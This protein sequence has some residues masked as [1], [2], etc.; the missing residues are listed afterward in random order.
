VCAAP[1][2]IALLPP[3]PPAGAGAAA[4]SL[5]PVGPPLTLRHTTNVAIHAYPPP[6]EKGVP[7]ACQLQRDRCIAGGAPIESPLHW[8]TGPSVGKTIHD[9]AAVHPRLESGGTLYIETP[10]RYSR[11]KPSFD[12]L[13]SWAAARGSTVAFAGIDHTWTAPFVLVQDGELLDAPATKAFW[14]HVS[15]LERYSGYVTEKVRHTPALREIRGGAVGSAASTSTS[16]STA[17]AT[18]TSA[19]AAAAAAAAATT[20]TTTTSS[21]SSSLSSLA[22]A[23]AGSA[24]TGCV[25]VYTRVSKRSPRDTRMGTPT[26]NVYQHRECGASLGAMAASARCIVEVGPAAGTG[27]AD[28]PQLIEAFGGGLATVVA[29]TPDRVSRATVFQR[30]LAALAVST[31]GMGSHLAAARGPGWAGPGWR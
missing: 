27:L 31:G 25:I 16:T 9:Y 8:Y 30:A 12:K 10:D 7:A 1:D 19:A 26:S 17:A 22:A 13:V 21:S 14:Q 23:L 11:V 18:T 6:V 24:A 4:R 20:T 3:L 5:R 28:W 29:H 2:A 15:N